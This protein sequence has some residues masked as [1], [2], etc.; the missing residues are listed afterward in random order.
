MPPLTKD[1]VD[2]LPAVTPGRLR[3][4]AVAE[5]TARPQPVC[6]EVPITVQGVRAGRPGEKREPFTET[7][8]TVIVFANG[9]V[10][11]LAAPVN[12][13]QPLFLTNERT[14]KEIVCQVVKSKT[15]A[16]VP[17]YVELEFTEPNV[18][19]WGMRFPSDT[20]QVEPV[21]TPAE[22]RPEEPRL[23]P[24]PAKSVVATDDIPAAP[25]GTTLPPAAAPP[26][27]I[28][29]VVESQPVA[30]LST[31][32]V[33]QP[34]PVPPPAKPAV[35]S[36]EFPVA[37]VMPVAPLPPVPSRSISSV[38]EPQS[39][40]SLPASL[41]EEARPVPPPAKR[42][43]V[44]DPF[45]AAPI[46]TEEPPAAAPPLNVPSVPHPADS[47]VH[48]APA[49]TPV[50]HRTPPIPPWP[51]V[52][53]PRQE[54]RVRVADSSASRVP[55]AP[56]A[57]PVSPRA[58]AS[59]HA[60]PLVFTPKTRPSQPPVA[61][62]ES[63]VARQQA[64]VFASSL[65][66]KKEKPRSN[67]AVAG[68]VA[69]GV[70][71]AVVGGG[72]Y[73]WQRSNRPSS[74]QPVASAS[75]ASGGAAPGAMAA[76]SPAALNPASSGATAASTQPGSRSSVPVS[77]SVSAKPEKRGKQSAPQQFRLSTPVVS[78]PSGAGGSPAAPDAALDAP[79]NAL[80]VA[81]GSLTGGPDAPL[82][83]SHPAAPS[84]GQMVPPKR[85]SA[86]PP[87]YPS[88]A[89]TQH[90]QGDV[91]LEVLVDVNGRPSTVKVLSGP[92]LLQQAAVSAVRQ[93]K[94]QPG[95]LN[96]TVVPM[97]LNVTLTFRLD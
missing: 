71:C 73:W 58:P 4:V 14:H 92:A 84:G 34:Q 72:W 27:S 15:Y 60:E 6:I 11:R 53:M 35:E 59:G 26:P 16:S 17:G 57:A 56:L 54:E 78:R 32:H 62:S 91:T 31:P 95:R 7:T 47:A 80:S 18:G 5:D 85:I 8:R 40:G 97:T 77:G 61:H 74:G 63:P 50:V 43:G 12:H 10:V 75:L 44:S 69:A 25:V 1:P 90:V 13:G 42:G 41:L 19:F 68:L 83:N 70:L 55:Q 39:L 89:R 96:G 21:S 38:P 76:G 64:E 65:L 94:Y 37:P 86:T 81:P 30:S 2:M 66:E 52:P 3:T 28:S 93:W 33:E 45:L 36:E 29:S 79:G 51:E 48:E 88:L 22:E 23:V 49:A 20:R 46:R 24:P 67:S 82:T 9:G 87:T